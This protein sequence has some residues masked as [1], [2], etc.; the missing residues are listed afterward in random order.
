MKNIDI[1]WKN[2]R[3]HRGETF[4]TKKGIPF[5]YRMG[6][7]TIFVDCKKCQI[8]KA[9]I[10]RTIRLQNPS[11]VRISQEGVTGSSYV[12]SFLHDY[13]IIGE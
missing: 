13:R 2:L 7:T 4:Y 5:T 10:E 1:I 11:V 6:E 9:M 3:L 8:S 12:Y